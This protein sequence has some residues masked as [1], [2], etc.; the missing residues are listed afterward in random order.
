MKGLFYLNLIKIFSGTTRVEEKKMIG[1]P[2]LLMDVR[3]LINLRKEEFFFK[4]AKMAGFMKGQE[5]K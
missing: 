4:E 3:D 1:I 5:T 2:E